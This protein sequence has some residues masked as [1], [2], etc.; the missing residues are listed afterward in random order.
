[1]TYTF[2]SKMPFQHLLLTIILVRLLSSFSNLWLISISSLSSAP[3]SVSS[4]SASSSST[5]GN[6][7]SS[8]ASISSNSCCSSSSSSWW[9]NKNPVRICLSHSPKQDTMRAIDDLF[10]KGPQSE[11]AGVFWC[12]FSHKLSSSLCDGPLLQFDT[13]QWIFSQ[14]KSFTCFTVHISCLF[15]LF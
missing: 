7:S 6:S 9:S 2:D 14:K 10:F 8:M 1:M 11:W 12:T 15:C 5:A 3:A 13:D 4:S